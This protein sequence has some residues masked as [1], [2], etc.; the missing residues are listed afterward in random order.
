MPLLMIGEVLLSVT[1]EEKE[2]GRGGREK[3]EKNQTTEN[4][5]TL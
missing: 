3:E 5:C 2:G 4:N 1:L